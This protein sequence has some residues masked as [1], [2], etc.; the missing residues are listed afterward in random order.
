MFAIFWQ[1]LLHWNHK[2]QLWT[3]QSNAHIWSL[4]R[5]KTSM[6]TLSQCLT[7]WLAMFKLLNHLWQV[8]LLNLQHLRQ[9]NQQKAVPLQKLWCLQNWRTRELLSL[10]ILQCMHFSLSERLTQ[11]HLRRDD[12]WLSYLFGR[13]AHEQRV[14]HLFELWSCYALEVLQRPG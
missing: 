7:I 14:I 6:H 5:Q 2:A 8:L 10:W 13:H 12:G 1:R 11:A 9:W 3:P 4:Q